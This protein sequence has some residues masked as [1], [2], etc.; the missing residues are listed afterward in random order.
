MLNFK[1]LNFSKEEIVNSCKS[2]LLKTLKQLEQSLSNKTIEHLLNGSDRLYNTRCG[3]DLTLVENFINDNSILRN[4][5][6]NTV[7]LICFDEIFHQEFI[8]ILAII[9]KYVDYKKFKQLVKDIIFSSTYLKKKYGWCALFIEKKNMADPIYTHLRKVAR[10]Y[11]NENFNND[12]DVQTLKKNAIEECYKIFDYNN[13]GSSN[14][15]LE[16][17]FMPRELIVMLSTSGW[18]N[19]RKSK[20]NKVNMHKQIKNIIKYIELSQD[21][22]ELGTIKNDLTQLG[23]TISKLKI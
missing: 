14:K 9:T 22:D 3:F 8:N 11:I 23:E 17:Y 21:Q 4:L 16:N 10:K 15:F 6:E 18:K 13:S 7:E 1:T 19:P 5:S 20:F 2:R 12:K